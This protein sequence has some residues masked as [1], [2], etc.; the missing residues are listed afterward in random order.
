[1]TDPRAATGAAFI[2]RLKAAGG[3]ENVLT[4]PADRWPYGQDNSRKHAQPD[5]VVFAVTHDQIV[6]VVRLCNEF[7]VPI[8]GRGRGTGTAGSAVPLQHGVVISF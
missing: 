6:R 2:E 8:V 7:S 5:A 3:H 1:M 4:D